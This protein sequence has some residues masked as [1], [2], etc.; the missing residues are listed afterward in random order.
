M[1]C[2]RAAAITRAAYYPC[3]GR[4]TSGNDV[5]AA[6]AAGCRSLTLTPPGDAVDGAT[7]LDLFGGDRQA[8]LLLHRS[9]DEAADDGPAGELHN[10]GAAGTF[11]PRRRPSGRRARPA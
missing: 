8:Q 1:S 3:A 2:G 4:G 10:F 11:R 5:N 9:G 7:P 6:R